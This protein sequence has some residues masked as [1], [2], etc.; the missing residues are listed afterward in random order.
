VGFADDDVYI[1]YSHL[2]AELEGVRAQ[3]QTPRELSMW[4]LIFWRPFYNRV[5]MCAAEGFLYQ[6]HD[7]GVSKERVRIERCH[8]ALDIE[9]RRQDA[10]RR[11]VGRVGDHGGGG[12]AAA[13]GGFCAAATLGESV[14]GMVERDEIN[15]SFAPTPMANGPLFTVSR[16]LAVALAAPDAEPQRW[17]DQFK[18]TELVQFARSR[19]RIPYKLRQTGCWPCG[20]A[21][22]GVW[23]AQLAYNRQHADVAERR[24][25]LIN[26]PLYTVHHV[27]PTRSH[28]AFRNTS[29]VLHGLK[30]NT[31]DEFWELAKQRGSGPF[32][33]TPRVCDSCFRMGWVT[34]PAS[35]LR[36]W[37]CCGRR[38][39]RAHWKHRP[40][41]V[42]RAIN[43]SAFW[44]FAVQSS[45]VVD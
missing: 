32:E 10:K 16:P 19:R 42:A 17:L 37:R 39:T 12:G 34:W 8:A 15:S 3:R 29:V 28:G 21:T 14:K 6:E 24:I 25:T 5:T 18:R 44:R 45:A 38:I 36:R 30:D 35:P 20:D 1:Q 27:M 33:P 43:S 26:A 31:T 11:R 7:G 9:K 22:F 41:T 4:G 40:N 23:L 13:A 2:A